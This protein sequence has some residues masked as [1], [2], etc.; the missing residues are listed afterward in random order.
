MAHAGR[1]GRNG[2]SRADVRD[3]DCVFRHARPVSA[4]NVGFLN[5]GLLDKQ[6]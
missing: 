6:P 2:D 3:G 1:A 4:I 5:D